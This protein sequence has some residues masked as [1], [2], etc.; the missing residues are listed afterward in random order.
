MAI[1]TEIQYALIDDLYL[2]PENPRLGREN[3]RS[4][5]SQS[6]LLELMADWT[7]DELATSFLEN[8]FWPQE[9]LLVIERELDGEK[10]LVVVEGNRRLAALKLLMAA[11]NGSADSA[12]MA[13][14]ALT[15]SDD[16]FQ[17]LDKVPYIKADTR[18]EIQ[19]YLG[20]RPGSQQKKQSL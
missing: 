10:R 15:G 14:I 17:R 9:A 1:N 5:L 18:D 11:R 3:S 13:S 4:Q 19:T 6:K 20:F 12:K 2:D 16:A 8:G 7:L